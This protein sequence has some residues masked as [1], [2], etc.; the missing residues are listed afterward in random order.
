VNQ[1]QQ[2]SEMSAQYQRYVDEMNQRLALQQGANQGVGLVPQTGTTTSDGTTTTKTSG[3]GPVVS[4]LAS[5]G[6][7]AAGI[8]SGGLTSGLGGILGAAKGTGG[9]LGG[10]SGFFG[11]SAANGLFK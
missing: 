10:S 1:Q 9:I 3:L 5:L 11:S 2:Q 8:A 7:V 4:G 6:Q